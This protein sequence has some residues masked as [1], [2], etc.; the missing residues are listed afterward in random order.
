MDD[1][2]TSSSNTPFLFSEIFREQF[3]YYLAM[4]MTYDLFWNQDVT[5]VKAYRKAFDIKQEQVNQQAWLEGLYVY[6]AL[7]DAAP[8]FR[9]L[10]KNNRA[11]EYPSQPLELSGGDVDPDD[12][13]KKKLKEQDVAVAYME[14]FAIDFN[15]K[16]EENQRKGEKVDGRQSDSGTADSGQC[17]GNCESSGQVSTELEQDQG[18][19]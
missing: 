8:L 1:G 2:L 10:G 14:S 13:E 19:S 16:F 3:P 6:T 12:K 7:C 4:G 18:R 17:C 9:S 5:L 15:K 11:R